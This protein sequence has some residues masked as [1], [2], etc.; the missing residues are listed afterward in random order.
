MNFTICPICESGALVAT[1]YGKELSHRG[2]TI[3]VEGLQAYVCQECGEL[4]LEA[5]QIKANQVVIAQARKELADWERT[6]Y[7]RL[8]SREIVRLRE[9]LHLNQ[10]QASKVFGGGANAFS[11]YERGDVLQ[12]EPMD[13]LMRCMMDVPE[14]AQWLLA[15]A[16]SNQ[17]IPQRCAEQP[18]RWVLQRGFNPVQEP[19]VQSSIASEQTEFDSR[20][21]LEAKSA[22]ARAR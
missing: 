14:A 5:S 20:E 22:G 11:K 4:T 1:T 17:D 8:S 18:A 6:Q 13:L 19:R 7:G 3:S 9:K 2:K 21:W 15:K 10:V 16:M 12:S